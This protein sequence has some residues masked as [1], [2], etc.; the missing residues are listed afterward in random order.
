MLK[1]S[2]SDKSGAAIIKQEQIIKLDKINNLLD[3][4]T[5][6]G[7]YTK[8]A[9]LILIIT[10]FIIDFPRGFGDWSIKVVEIT[11][12]IISGY[13]LRLGI[14]HGIKKRR[15]SKDKTLLEAEAKRKNLL[16]EKYINKHTQILVDYITLWAK[17]HK[18]KFRHTRHNHLRNVIDFE[19]FPIDYIDINV[20][21]YRLTFTIRVNDPDFINKISEDLPRNCNNLALV[22]DKYHIGPKKPLTLDEVGIINAKDIIINVILSKIYNTVYF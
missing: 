3:E 7:F 1:K 18:I 9:S 22:I 11:V 13:G 8:I 17:F 16:L 6:I 14:N 12:I 5:K 21:N 10:S 20:V 4:E 19:D 15:A 2:L